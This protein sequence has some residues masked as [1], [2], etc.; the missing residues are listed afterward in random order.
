MAGRRE[1][2]HQIRCPQPHLFPLCLG[3]PT[4]LFRCEDPFDR[5]PVQI[6][7]PVRNVHQVIEPV[8][9]DQDGLALAL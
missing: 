6:H 2:V 9:R 7:D 8:L 4:E 5:S 3:Q 1:D